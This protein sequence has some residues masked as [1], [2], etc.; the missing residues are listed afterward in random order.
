MVRACTYLSPGLL[1][2]C[3]PERS[4]QKCLL[5]T[6]LNVLCARAFNVTKHQR[7]AF[8]LTKQIVVLLILTKHKRSAFNVTK[9]ERS[10][11]I[12]VCIT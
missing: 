9:H 8:I 4:V 10:A 7:S 2:G 1:A 6:N 11:F 12:N 5:G 3:K